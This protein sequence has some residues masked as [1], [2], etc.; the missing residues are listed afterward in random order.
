MDGA[1]LQDEVA[2]DRVRAAIEFLDPSKCAQGFEC[3]F[4][5]NMAIVF[6]QA[7]LEPAGS[8][9]RSIQV[10]FVPTKR[11]KKQLSCRHRG[12]VESRT[13]PPDCALF[14]PWNGRRYG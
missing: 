10:L 11:N 6:F 13:A 4:L 9:K 3:F 2:Q 7:M 1:Q 12:D 8:L 5:S 14:S